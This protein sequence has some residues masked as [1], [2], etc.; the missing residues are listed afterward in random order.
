MCSCFKYGFNLLFVQFSFYALP[1]LRILYINCLG[2]IIGF[3][4]KLFLKQETFQKRA[5]E[6]LR[7]NI[8]K[9]VCLF[10]QNISRHSLGFIYLISLF[11][12][13]SPRFQL[14]V[15]SATTDIIQLTP[16]FRIHVIQN[17]IFTMFMLFWYCILFF[18]CSLHT[19]NIL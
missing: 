4:R 13:F 7:K 16:L 15:G 11:L 17:F 8:L 18:H 5:R 3:L 19:L 2:D 14:I 12:I 9:I 6:V 10:S 1:R